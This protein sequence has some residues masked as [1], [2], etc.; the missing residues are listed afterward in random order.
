M[1]RRVGWT[2]EALNKQRI[3]SSVEKLMK[4]TVNWVIKSRI[5]RWAGHIH[6]YEEEERHI[7]GFDGEV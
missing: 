4:I 1:Y 6:M 5:V 3:V 7:Q 2:K